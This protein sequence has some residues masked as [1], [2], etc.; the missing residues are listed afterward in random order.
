M[1]D[2]VSNR[3]VGGIAVV[4][5]LAFAI[6]VVDSQGLAWPAL[7]ALG[8]LAGLA[9]SVAYWRS[10]QPQRS[11]AQVLCGLEG[12]PILAVAATRVRHVTSA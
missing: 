2:L 6:A 3:M 12:M 5:A 1:N 11:I 9:T 8:L 4:S 10:V 7:A